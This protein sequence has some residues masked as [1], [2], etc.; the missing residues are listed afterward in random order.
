MPFKEK[1]ECYTKVKAFF[2][3]PKPKQRKFFLVP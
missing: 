1:K 2:V 3:T